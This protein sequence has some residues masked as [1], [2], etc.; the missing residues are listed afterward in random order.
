MSLCILG[1]LAASVASTTTSLDAS[2]TSY[3]SVTTKNVSRHSQM[4]L[5]REI[6]I[7]GKPLI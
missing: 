2:S 4:S 3:L 1:C 6:A 7:C 5:G